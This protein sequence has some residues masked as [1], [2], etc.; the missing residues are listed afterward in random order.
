[1]LDNNIELNDHNIEEKEYIT[2]NEAMK[3]LG[4][5]SQQT[6]YRYVNKG[7]LNPVNK[8]DW[9]IDGVYEFKYTD[10]IELKDN[11]TPKDYT[12][13]DVAKI[14]GVSQ[15]TVLK[16]IEQGILK[17]HKRNF[18][19]LVYNF[20][21]KNDLRDFQINHK[22]GKRH[23]KQSFY[24]QNTGYALYQKFTQGNSTARIISLSDGIKVIK[25]NYDEDIIDRI[26][27]DGFTP[28]YVIEKKKVV[29][30]DGFAKFKFKLPAAVDNPVFSVID[31]FYK[32]FSPTNMR[33]K[34]LMD[35][36]IQIEVKPGLVSEQYSGLVDMLQSHIIEGKVLLRRNGIY[37]DSDIAPIRLKVSNKVKREFEKK[38]K[39]YDMSMDEL[40]VTAVRK[41]EL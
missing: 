29:T 38:A 5:E 14:L 11:L 21:S 27:D 36:Y 25:D 20:I 41:F 2:T 18:R 17:A 34:K 22:I 26:E 8:D 30:K 1:M 24:D 10:V 39:Q 7:I 19:G 35:D 6:I 13:S 40:I 28:E 32:E 31:M 37:I 4:V 12:T 23:T 33:L 9:K 3:I 16:Y 15:P